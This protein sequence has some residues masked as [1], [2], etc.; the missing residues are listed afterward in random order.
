MCQQVIIPIDD[1]DDDEYTLSLR[2]N[3]EHPIRNF[4]GYH[5]NKDN[6]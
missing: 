4:T 1:A 2:F 6:R 5:N 3:V